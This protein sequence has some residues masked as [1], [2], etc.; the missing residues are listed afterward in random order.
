MLATLLSRFRLELPDG[1]R[2]DPRVT[3]TMAPMGGLPMT[4]RRRG[5]ATRSGRARGKVRDWARLPS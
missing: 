3:I 4:T 2:V 5:D 1:A